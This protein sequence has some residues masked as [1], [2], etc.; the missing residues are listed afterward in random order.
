VAGDTFHFF[1]IYCAALVNDGDARRLKYFK[2]NVS[3]CHFV[4]YKFYMDWSGIEPRS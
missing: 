4:Y 2:K 1:T 3:Q